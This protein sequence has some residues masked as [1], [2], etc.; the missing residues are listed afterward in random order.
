M[1]AAG[2]DIESERPAAVSHWRLL[3]DQALLTPHVLSSSFHGQGTETEPFIVE[4]DDH[5]P[6]NPQGWAKWYKW[7]ITVVVAIASLAVSFCSSA[8]SGGIADM[9]RDFDIS[10][11]VAVLG[12]SLFVVGFALGPLL[13]APLS[14]LYG[15]Q[16]IF[17]VTFGAYAAFN[18]GAAGSQNTET[19]LILRFLAG[20]F[21]S[22][23]LTNAGG[24]IADMFEAEERGLAMCVF[25]I[26]PFMGPGPVVGG[27]LGET[28][29]WRWLEGLMAIFSGTL[30][31]VGTLAVPETYGPVILRKRAEKLARMTGKHYRSIVD[32]DRGKMTF[33]KVLNKSMRRPW[34]LLFR[35]PIVLLLTI[36]LAI[37]YG[38]LYMLFGAFPVVY[39]QH[40]QWTQGV[41]GLPFLGV[42]IGMVVSM[43]Y[44]ILDNRRYIQVV[45]ANHGHAPPESRLPPSI[46]GSFAL[47][48]GLFWFAWTSGA[49]VPWPAS[50][51]AGIPFGFGMVLVFMG[52]IN[53]LVDSYTIYAASVMAANSVLRSLFGAAFPL[54]TVQMYNKLGIH[55]ASSLA[56][57][58]ALA[59]LPFPWLFYKY[60]YA[61]RVRCKY[62]AQAEKFAREMRERDLRDE[63][64]DGIEQSGQRTPDNSD[65]ETTKEGEQKAAGKSE[66]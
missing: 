27:F 38:I 53:Y 23:P 35:E 47:P 33:Q 2:A 36:Y 30:W 51:A 29:G 61:V 59:C 7:I 31:I 52:I 13:W 45:K 22:S 56:A 1:E 64:E 16:V 66:E 34:A 60:G 65:G 32:H 21:G 42:A 63:P 39:Q 57:F 20:S 37:V 4:W 44:N 55:W 48:V 28:A 54:F 15:R 8:Y 46:V 25:S 49:S 12:L 50:V 58:L 10:R 19:V 9:M 40:R 24:V 11:E 5:D 43:L 18:A 17:F 41:A 26:A 14:E 62:A 6:R 3:A